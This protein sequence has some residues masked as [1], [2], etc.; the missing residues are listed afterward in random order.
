MD[1]KPLVDL[2]NINTD[3]EP[4]NVPNVPS[5]MVVNNNVSTPVQSNVNVTNTVP[6]NNVNNTNTPVGNVPKKKVKKKKFKYTFRKIPMLL[7]TK[8]F[9]GIMGGVFGLCIIAVILGIFIPSVA[10]FMWF[11]LRN[12]Y[13]D[14]GFKLF[15]NIPNIG[16]N[17]ILVL[18]LVILFLLTIQVIFENFRKIK[19]K[20]ALIV[21]N[22]ISCIVFTLLTLFLVLPMGLDFNTYN[23]INGLKIYTTLDIH[24]LRIILNHK[25]IIRY[26]HTL[27]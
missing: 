22:V 17:L 20:I 2:V 19:Y 23:N 27:G 18:F 15:N 25:L 9:L 4:I 6:T 24:N 7:P 5:N 1:N 8:I 21:S 26:K 13:Y 12:P 16:S 11:N 10:E 14:L 3:S